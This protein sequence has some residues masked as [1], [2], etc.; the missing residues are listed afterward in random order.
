MVY[1]AQPPSEGFLTR[2][3]NC[4]WRAGSASTSNNPLELTSSLPV[5][6]YRYQNPKQL[7]RRTH[8]PV[9]QQKLWYKHLLTRVI[10]QRLEVSDDKLAFLTFLCIT[11]ERTRIRGTSGKYI[12]VS[13]FFIILRPQYRPCVTSSHPE[14]NT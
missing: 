14:R 6:L 8:V 9:P 12:P 4:R 5:S 2:A 7:K 1:G 13:V 11:N 10:N 3:G